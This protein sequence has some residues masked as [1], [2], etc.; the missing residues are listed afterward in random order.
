V[1]IGAVGGACAVV[2]E[3]EIV[4]D[5]TTKLGGTGLGPE[6]PPPPQAERIPV[7]K[8]TAV[9]DKRATNPFDIPH[10]PRMNVRN[11]VPAAMR[12]PSSAFDGSEPGQRI[13]RVNAALLW[14]NTLD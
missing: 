1:L 3:T 5:A 11:V 4:V 10:S 2:A 9:T 6:P 7:T 12:H 13:D 8:Q 14:R